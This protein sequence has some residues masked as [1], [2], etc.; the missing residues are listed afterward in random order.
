VG[1]EA[2]YKCFDCGKSFK[3]REGGGFHFD[4]LRCIDCDY[5]TEVGLTPNGKTKKPKGTYKC[6]IC[7]GRMLSD[8]KPMC[9]FCHSRKSEES[10]IISNYD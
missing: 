5:T 4:L 3:S 7:G 2:I 1:Q 10:E 9:P 8:I 6:V